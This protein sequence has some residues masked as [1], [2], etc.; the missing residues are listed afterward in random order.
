MSTKLAAAT[1]DELM[2]QNAQRKSFTLQ[3]E[4]LVDSIYVK[5]ER[6]GATTVSA[7]D[8]DYKIFPAASISL[9]FQSDG[10]EAIKERWTFIASANTPR[11]AIVET[12]DI[13]R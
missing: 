2:P 8:H 1:A 7:T 6:P 4:D 11:I 5:K 13:K 12:E 9:N 3:N 10:E